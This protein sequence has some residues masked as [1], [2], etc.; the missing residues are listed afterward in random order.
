MSRLRQVR[1]FTPYD[2]QPF[3]KQSTDAPMRF[4]EEH[5]SGFKPI[6]IG[7]M[8]SLVEIFEELSGHRAQ[9]GRELS[10]STEDVTTDPVDIPAANEP[11]PALSH[12]YGAASVSFTVRI[13]DRSAV[14]SIADSFVFA[15]W[16]AGVAPSQSLADLPGQYGGAFAAQ[17][18]PIA[19]G[20][21]A[22][23]C[24]AG[25]RNGFHATDVDAPEAPAVCS[26]CALSAEGSAQSMA[27]PFTLSNGKWGSATTGTTGGVVTWSIAGAGLS[28]KTPAVFFEG[29]TVFLSDI[30]QFDFTSVL[31]RAFAAWSAIAN[32]TFVQELDGGGDIGVGKNTDIRISAGYIDGPSK[33]LAQA[34]LPTAGVNPKNHASSGDIVFDS[35]ENG[36]WNPSGL[37]TVAMHEIGHAIGLS[38]SSFGTLMAPAYDRSITAPQADDIAGARAIYGASPDRPGS[39]WIS[40]VKIAEGD[41]GTKVMTFTVTRSNGNTPF[42]VKFATEDSSAK[43]GTDYV[44]RSGT[45]SF[46]AGEISKTIDITILGDTLLEA[47]ETFLLK[48]SNATKG[49]KIDNGV[50]VGTILNDDTAPAGSVS[51]SDATIIEG[52]SGNQQVIFTVTRTGGAAAFDVTYTTADGTATSAGGDYYGKASTV[53]FGI[54]VN[55]QTI[56][57]TVRGDRIIEPDETFYVN[58]SGVTNGAKITKGQ[59][60]GTILN[61]DSDVVIVDPGRPINPDPGPRGP[62][63]GAVHEATAAADKFAGTV[64]IDTVNYAD[65]PGSRGVVASLAN[66]KK[67]TGYAAGDT[68]SSIENLIGTSKADVLTGDTRDNILEG[69]GGA[70]KLDGGLGFDI[71]SYANAAAGVTANLAKPKSNTGEAFGDTYKSIEGLLGSA[72]N[73]ILIGGTG[74]D[75]I[76]GGAGN[77][78]IN[79]GAKTDTLTGGAGWDTFVFANLKEA[80]D[81]ITDFTPGEDLI[82]IVRKGFKIDARVDFD[83]GG[84]F[85]FADKYFVSNTTGLADAVGHGQFVFNTTTDRLL[86]DPDGMGTKAAVLVA[87]FTTDVNL[88]AYDFDLI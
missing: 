53:S 41:A 52:D 73:D 47:E 75:T 30:F 8:E 21:H 58:L 3:M 37:L 63:F 12:E 24:A 82:G 40:H 60:V 23:D 9:T 65:Q 22:L 69:R 68:Y 84:A 56:S 50:G 77:D 14:S 62:V 51:I 64:G 17:A 70:D 2:M 44:A 36:F 27:A 29:K 1:G 83:A 39:L 6:D 81:I 43:A 54:G 16:S 79:G 35:G 20:I 80:G 33:T 61:D 57:V 13:P 48:L 38:H 15:A 67:N 34:F 55:K 31:T 26:C 45:L 11:A 88:T 71:A 78:V 25:D 66:P 19:A 59:G 86:W 72:F 85:A 10:D 32:I 76:V 46:A 28:D 42:K 7:E 87:R 49:V 18:A 4:V 5:V 74:A